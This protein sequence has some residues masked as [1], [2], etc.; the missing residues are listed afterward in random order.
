M[1]HHR[2]MNPHAWPLAHAEPNLMNLDASSSAC[3][4]HCDL[5]NHWYVQLGRTSFQSKVILSALCSRVARTSMWGRTKTLSPPI[6]S[7]I[8]CLEKNIETRQAHTELLYLYYKPQVRKGSEHGK[9]HSLWQP[10]PVLWEGNENLHLLLMQPWLPVKLLGRQSSQHLGG[11]PEGYRRGKLCVR[12]AG[13]TELILQTNG[14]ASVLPAPGDCT[15][16]VQCCH[17]HGNNRR[18]GCG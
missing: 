12:Q 2:L 14:L 6:F 16:S 17:H 18:W 8:Q 5:I 11:L 10:S 1:Y 13:V 4:Q 7:S 3:K 9:W 15:L